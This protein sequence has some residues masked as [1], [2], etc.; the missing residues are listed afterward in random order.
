M[1]LTTFLFFICV[2]TVSESW[3]ACDQVLRGYF[4]FVME[5]ATVGL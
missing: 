2:F 1:F 4:V 5:M 3:T